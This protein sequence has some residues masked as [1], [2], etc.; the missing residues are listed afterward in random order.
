MQTSESAPIWQD[1]LESLFGIKGLIRKKS[2]TQNV[3]KQSGEGQP[4][5]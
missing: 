4:K 1:T 3:E 5:P 2:G